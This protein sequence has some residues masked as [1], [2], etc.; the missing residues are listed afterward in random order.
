MA[1]PASNSHR[2]LPLVRVE[3]VQ[4]AVARAD[5]DAPAG[6]DRRRIDA[7]PRHEL[8]GA[9]AARGV[10]RVHR[11]VAAADD[12]PAA[13]SAR[14]TSSR[15]TRARDRGR[16]T[17]PSGFQIDREH[18]GAERADDTRDRL[19]SPPTSRCWIRAG[20]RTASCRRRRERRGTARRSRRC[21]SRRSE[22]PAWRGPG[23]RSAASTA[24]S[25]CGCRARRG[26]CRTI[27]SSST[28][29]TSTGDDLISSFGLERPELA[30]V[31]DADGVDDAGEIADEHRVGAHRRRRFADEPA[32]AGRVL[33]AQLAAFRD[34]SRAVRPS[35]IRRRRR[36][37][38]L[39]RTIQSTRR[40]R[41]S[42][43]A[44]ASPEECVVATPVRL[45]LPRNWGQLAGGVCAARGT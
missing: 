6:D 31:A 12:H 28:S 43:S 22:P 41:R 36:R 23:R 21:R 16:S 37:R 30:A 7:R 13:A 33:P 34:R 17:R 10:D 9:L 26:S 29:S 1:S 40:P 44:P 25:R 3:H 4:L 39:R 5:V 45:A 18:V 24:L 15:G 42:T 32:V 2:F 27:R 19:R 8:P 11:L 14:R 38:R 35:T 20:A